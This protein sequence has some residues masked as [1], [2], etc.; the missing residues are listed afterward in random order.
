[1]DASSP[2]LPPVAAPHIVSLKSRHP[3]SLNIFTASPIQSI[4]STTSTPAFDT[5]GYEQPTK[6]LDPVVAAPP[7][8]RPSIPAGGDGYYERTAK[9][10][11]M[12]MP[13]AAL[14]ISSS[15][16]SSSSSSA[17]PLSAPRPIITPSMPAPAL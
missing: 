16:S 15:S 3:P 13:S 7:S 6:P 4:A 10:I 12:A 17:V 14:G 9:A 5:L 11:A 1:M 2:A 8:P